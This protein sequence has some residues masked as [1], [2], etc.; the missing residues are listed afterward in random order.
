MGEKNKTTKQQAYIML[1]PHPPYVIFSSA[2]KKQKK[3]EALITDFQVVMK[4]RT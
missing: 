1:H 2:S 3:L 4:T